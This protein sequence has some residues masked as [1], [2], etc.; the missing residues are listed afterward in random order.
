[1]VDYTELAKQRAEA[2]AKSLNITKESATVNAT[3]SFVAPYTHSTVAIGYTITQEDI[4]DA[5]TRPVADMA[6]PSYR[7]TVTDNEGWLA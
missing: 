7:S 6:K 4:D 1:M 5:P 2:L 3:G